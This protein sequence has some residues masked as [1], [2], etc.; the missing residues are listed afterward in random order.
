MTKADIDKA[1]K[2]AV[3]VERARGND[4]LRAKLV[5]LDLQPGDTLIVTT[6]GRLTEEHAR[7]FKSCF[8]EVFP[9]N[10]AVVVENGVKIKAKRMRRR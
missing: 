7:Q 2:T 6:D 9:Q 10:K 3:A 1:V 8:E 5:K 4:L